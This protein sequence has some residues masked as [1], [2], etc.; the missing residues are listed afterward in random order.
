[1]RFSRILAG[2]IGGGLLLLI[3]LL[4]GPAGFGRGEP[5]SADAGILLA[6]RQHSNEKHRRGLA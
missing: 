4:S 5:Q 2:A 3:G 6:R 1:M